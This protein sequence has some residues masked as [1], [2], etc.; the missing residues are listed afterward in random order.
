MTAW[1]EAIE[2]ALLSECALVVGLPDTGKTT[3][4]R[5]IA[6]AAREEGVPVGLVDGDIGQK[7]IGPPCVVGLGLGDFVASAMH[8]VGDTTPATRP[9]E[10]VIGAYLMA[11]EARRRGCRP[12]VVDTSGLASGE[13]GARLKAA[14]AQLLGAD[15]AI[16][17]ERRG[18]LSDLA[19]LFVSR[20][21]EV[22]RV[23]AP[24]EA[25]AVSPEER[26]ANRRERFA[27]YFADASAHGMTLRRVAVQPGPGGRRLSEGLL[28]GLL[29][30]SW[31][32]IA[33]GIALKT[34]KFTIEVL[35]PPF[36]VRA[37]RLIRP[38]ILRISPEGQELGRI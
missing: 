5:D 11:L 18:E 25:R 19:D 30:D 36:D 1:N 22:L 12:V 9:A 13:L 34:T 10:A 27:A 3:L 15:V 21:M 6:E 24:A 8:F 16:V 23:K 2:K 37:V 35:A 29:D 7:T 4:F 31:A 20:K 33:M 17:L 28:V 14:K 32:T 26:A 38:G